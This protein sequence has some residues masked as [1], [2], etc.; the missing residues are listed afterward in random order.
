MLSLKQEL[1][2]CFAVR[3]KKVTTVRV[4]PECTRNGGLVASE[5]LRSSCPDLSPILAALHVLFLV[6]EGS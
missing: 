5:T 6:R 4:I 3:F 2:L 1:N